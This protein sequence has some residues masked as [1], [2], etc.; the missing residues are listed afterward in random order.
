M[1]KVA[2]K[3]VDAHA[4]KSARGIPVQLNPHELA[5]DSSEEFLELASTLKANGSVL[6]ADLFCGAGGLSLGLERAGFTTVMGIDHDEDACATHRHHFPGLSETWDLHDQDVVAE[7]GRLVRDADVDLVAGG[8]PCQPFSR[9]GHAM[10]RD[11]VRTGRRP[12]HD[13]RVDLWQSFLEVV[14][15]SLPR[16]VLMENVP[17]MVLDRDMLVLRT[18]V[19]EL[20]SLGYGVEARIVDAWRY[21][22]PQPRQ[23]L[24]LVA[25]H[26]GVRFQ[27]PTP[28]PN[29]VTLRQ[30]IGDLPTVEGGWHTEDAKRGWADYGG[31]SSSF[32]EHARSGVRSSE[33]NK[34][35]DHVTR[36]VRTDDAQA[37]ALMGP[38]TKYTDL[39]DELKRY[40]DDIFSDKYKRLDFDDLSRTVTAHLAKDGYG[41]I[42]PTEDRTITIREAARIQSFP[43]HFRFSGPPTH[44]FRQIGNAVPPNLGYHLGRQVL[45]QLNSDADSARNTRE[46]TAA[47]AKWVGSVAINESN[48]SPW[49]IEPVRALTSGKA[50][51]REM[52]WL[53]VVGETLFDRMPITRMVSATIWPRLS[54]LAGSP[55]ETIDNSKLVEQ[56]AFSLDRENRADALFAFAQAAVDDKQ[57]L[58]SHAG[59][60]AIP[61]LTKSAAHFVSRVVPD[62]IVD[63]VQESGGLTRVAFR[64]E[65]NGEKRSNMRT[66]GRMSI[67]R[68]IGVDDEGAAD[69]ITSN[70]SSLAHIALIDISRRVC[71][72][73]RPIC[74]SCPLNDDCKGAAEF[75]SAQTRI[76][77][78]D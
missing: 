20:E 13:E 19:D 12:A 48:I 71:K 29:S 43:D 4:L 36:P 11:L 5:T 34:V 21:E 75:E 54:K 22:V 9:A 6:A 58:E 42:H 23:R 45:A 69:P 70:Q 61:G 62:G 64:Y 40:R 32:Q 41:F 47:L 76:P 27:W 33:R 3:K 74:Y 66:D 57:L 46:V 26:N 52:R 49:F 38:D 8:P 31:P 18:M 10:L 53:A 37:F 2:A 68:I 72:P 50:V 35:F 59:L 65:G 60:L 44:A 51:T 14:R 78:E 30:A 73:D 15:I 55:A 24:I 1:S 16:A 67:A 56:I 77:F 25:I 17:G 7:I 63:P 39:P 28:S